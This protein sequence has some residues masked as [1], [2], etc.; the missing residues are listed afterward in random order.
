MTRMNTDNQNTHPTC[1]SERS[2]ESKGTADR[3][4]QLGSFAPLRLTVLGNDGACG[5][6]LRPRT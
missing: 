5:K 2:E 1:H 6:I 4:Q 3:G